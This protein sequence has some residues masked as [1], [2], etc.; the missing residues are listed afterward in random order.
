MTDKTPDPC[1]S[2]SSTELSMTD[3]D[4]VRWAVKNGWKYIYSNDQLRDPEGFMT[5]A[6]NWDSIGQG[7]RNQILK[8]MRESTA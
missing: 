8:Q 7:R 3:R 4:L 6:G 2:D 5:T 1:G